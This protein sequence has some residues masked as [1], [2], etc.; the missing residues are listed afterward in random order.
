MVLTT[1]HPAIAMAM[2]VRAPIKLP[3]PKL[4]KARIDTKDGCYAHSKQDTAMSQRKG[5]KQGQE[6]SA[7]EAGVDEVEPMRAEG[8]WWMPRPTGR[9]GCPTQAYA[10]DRGRPSL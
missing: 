10:I 8:A 4:E 9:P 3:P 6:L 2:A 1:P 7:T 5:Y